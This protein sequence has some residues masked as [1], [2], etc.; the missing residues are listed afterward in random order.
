MTDEREK[1][2]PRTE[3]F[4]ASTLVR[5]PA[6]DTRWTFRDDAFESTIA[7][8]SDATQPSLEPLEREFATRYVASTLLGEGGM[9]VVRLVSD[10]RI[11]R[12]VAMKTMRLERRENADVATR[13]V[14]EACVQGQ[15]EHPAIVPVYD[16]GVDPVR[17]PYFTMKRVIGATFAEIIE[18]L[19]AGDE[20]A[21]RKF[22][23]Q[24]L[25]TAFASVC[26]AVDFAHTR[27]VV[28]RDLKPH[29]VML[30][31]FGEVYVLD[32]GVAKVVGARDVSSGRASIAPSSSGAHTVAGVAMG[33]PG[34]MAPEQA[35]G[36]PDIDARADVYALGAI[37][38]ELLALD[39]LHPQD[40][41]S[42][43]LASTVRGADARPSVRAP[44][45]G[46]APE[47]D[48]LCSLA[49][50]VDRAARFQSVHAM[51]GALDQF[52]EGDRD[53]ER[54]RELASEH[55]ARAQTRTERALSEADDATQARRDA[56]Q[57][58]G[59]ALALDPE[60]PLAM[61]TLVRLLVTPPRE[62]PADALAALRESERATQRATS[63]GA[64]VGYLAWFAFVPFG[65]WMGVRSV[66][67]AI[68]SAI[69]WALAAASTSIALRQAG[70]LARALALLA[71]A[72]A[73]G[74]TS[75]ICGPY[76]LVPTLAVI[77]VILWLLVGS[78]SARPVVIGLAC[79]SI[80]APAALDWTRLVRFYHFRDGH[81]TL[82]QGLLDF[83]PV[84][85][86]ALLLA[87][88]LALVGVAAVL[89][90]RFRDHLDE[91]ER[92]L[93]VQ[94]WQLEQLVPRAAEALRRR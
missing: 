82:L 81:V 36:E 11:G 89:V 34:Y 8:S 78:R 6:E 2:P 23:R 55:A 44:D 7:P 73:A 69:V 80:L 30:G 86:H 35:R 9:G 37:L 5:V 39:P 52:L 18:R 4:R 92:R 77:N 25:L 12:D 24:K 71:T 29:N 14:R 38:F 63:R 76:V 68:A 85:T 70:T 40:E 22:T 27:G 67:A 88:S 33:T 32:W 62:I 45:R 17:A 26:Q 66:S 87:A 91:T 90:T 31:D 47:L 51:L 21:A 61:E 60:N 84:A 83:P 19:R 57:E 20:E 41:V 54:R 28:H 16:V 13:F 53:L 58:I 74:V 79:L 94:A 3:R 93:Y 65:F 56:L 46:I 64:L 72:A 1:L 59:R 15:L 43:R 48:A 42:A 49:C 50:A 75:M 10:R